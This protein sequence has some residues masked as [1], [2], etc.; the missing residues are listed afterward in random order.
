MRAA[1]LAAGLVLAAGSGLAWAES[2]GD[3]EAGNGTP[4]HSHDAAKLPHTEWSFTGP[5]G[6]YDRA[7][8][9]RGFQVYNQVCS[10]CHSMRLVSYRNL[11][12][13]GLSEEQVKALAASVQ[14][15]TTDDSGQPAERPG[16]PSDR[17]KAPYP[18]EKAAR[19]SNGGALPPDQS[20]IVKAREH[21]PDYIHALLN[22][23]QDAPAGVTVPPGQYYNIYFNGNLL[24]MPPPLAED[25]VSYKDGTKATVEQMS[26]DVVYFLTWASNPEMEARKRLGIKAVLF[27]TFMTG[28]TYAVKRKVWKDVH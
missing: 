18:N 7:A 28:L 21:G 11:T 13:I 22:G 6:T 9:Q 20:L 19:A 10:N 16:L 25:Q 1:V 15:P 8:L 5:F 12:Q 26:K 23:Y 14:M 3:K 2:P 17:L 24:A 27:L 4:D